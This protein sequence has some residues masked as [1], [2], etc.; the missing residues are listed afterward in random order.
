MTTTTTS[1]S[2]ESSSSSSSRKLVGA[3][4]HHRKFSSSSS[5]SS[6][7]QK[8]TTTTASSSIR[9][10]S[11]HA[12]KQE[13]NLQKV[14][15]NL[16]EGKDLSENEAFEAMEALLDAS[17]NQIAAFLVLLRAKGETSS[18]MAGLARA[19]QSR[20]VQ[21]NAGDDVLDI[22]GTGGDSAGT[23]NISTGSRSVSSLCG[24]ADV[25]E[26]LGVAVEIGPEAIE[27]CVK[28]VGM[29][30]MFA[31]RFHPAMAK[32]SPVRKSLK[33]RTAFN[34]LGPMLNPAH[35]KYALVGVYSTDIQR[36][37]ADSFMRLG[38]KKALIVHSMGLDELT[39]CGPADV[40]EV[41]KDG[42]KTYTFEP[43]KVGIKKCELKD[44]AGGDAKL[45]AK[46][47]REALGG[48]TGP[49]AETLI[50]N[51]GVA[52]AAAE[53]AASV[54]EGIAMCRE[55]HK[56]GKGGEKLDRWI[57]LTQECKK[58]GL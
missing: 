17:E 44:L 11:V 40:M 15:E 8:R 43:S 24:S 57:Q 41:S 3:H 53:Q 58:A 47:L 37:M 31:P 35:S 19:M 48:E 42:V 51:A 9:T 21:V 33:V 27:K 36:L 1:S 25:L 38:M 6:S 26:A 22:V 20:A 16:C 56:T 32:V 4:Q 10:H 52:M 13:I 5:S 49:V 2:S 45:N 23:V 7:R 46:I 39:P 55:A 30:F 50:L 34:L 28:E 12:A 29:G 54:E 14:I 18:E